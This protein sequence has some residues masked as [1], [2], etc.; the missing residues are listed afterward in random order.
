MSYPLE[1]LQSSP[2]H[3]AAYYTPFPPYGP[4]GNTLIAAEEDFQP[5]RQ[6]AAAVSASQAMHPFAFR[7]APPLLSPGLAVQREPLYDLPW[8]G[9]LPPWYPFPHFPT[10]PQHLLNGSREDAGAAREDLAHVGSRSNGGP[11]YGPE[12][13]IPPP[14]VDASLLPERPKTSHL[15]PSF[16]SKQSEDGP[17]LL[18]PE[19]ESAHRYHFTQEDLHLVLYGV[20]PSLEP[21][22]RL[23]HAA[24]GL[25]VPADG[26]GKGSPQPRGLRGRGTPGCI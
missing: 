13:S 5:F 11:C 19:G 3:L 18:N 12:I 21:S 15:L 1:R 7:T 2:Q 22:A 26:S 23:H 20:I 10:E 17:K 4:Y 24:S 9:K 8:H 16:P 25:L 6:L 14:P